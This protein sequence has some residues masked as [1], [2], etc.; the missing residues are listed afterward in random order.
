MAKTDDLEDRSTK[1][2]TRWRALG[3]CAW[4]SATVLNLAK[5]RTC[6]SEIYTHVHQTRGD[7]LAVLKNSGCS[8][9]PLTNYAP[10]SWMVRQMG[11]GRGLVRTANFFRFEGVNY[12]IYK[13]LG[14]GCYKQSF[15]HLLGD[16]WCKQ[17]IIYKVKEVCIRH[18]QD[19]TWSL[20]CEGV[21][22]F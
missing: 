13:R 1:R 19:E 5:T 14:F 11:H 7:L 17:C 3:R 9:L 6:V 12:P 21:K 4:R 10:G 22:A 15:P 16:L 2:V 18:K 8:D 20:Y